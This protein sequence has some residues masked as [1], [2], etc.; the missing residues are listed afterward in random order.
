MSLTNYL[1]AFYYLQAMN[2]RAFWDRGKLRRYQNKKLR[3][4]VMYAYA[5]SPFYRRKFKQTEIRP[6]EIRTIEDLNKLPIIRK[7]ELIKNLDDVVSRTFNVT[8]LKVQRTSGSTGRPLYIYMTES[9]NEFRKA[10][11][12]RA[13]I[14][15]GQKPWHKWIT[16]TSPLHFAETTR[17]QRLLGLYAV[18]PISV[19]DDIATQISKIEKLKPEVLDGYS[20]SILLL[21]KEVHKRGLETIKPKFLVSGAELIDN[22]S[23][24]FIEDVFAAPLY[25]QYASVE[26]ERMAWQCPEKT[27]YH[28]DSDSLVMQFIDENGDEVEP[29]EEG[30]IVCTSLFNYAMPFIRYALDDV[31]I[32]S[33]TAE[34]PCGRTFPLMKVME[35]R[36]TSLLVFPSGR[37][38]APF[39]FMLAVW[40]FKYYGCIDLFRI[41]QKRKDLILFKLRLNE[42][43]VDESAIQKELQRHL[44][45][46]LNIKEDETTFEV[47]FVD[48]MPPDKT[49]KFQIV[50][51]E[52]N[53]EQI[54]DI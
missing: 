18:T 39:A 51:S 36:K 49:G 48:E 52:V 23:R 9:E 22:S 14:V 54:R 20:N 40:N 47:E 25:D 29:G 19:F 53:Q 35:G 12:L 5:N 4:I 16:I 1:R 15:C 46:T 21:A 38:L 37:V 6:E 33:E 30:E 41:I 34:C 7:D 31:G 2:R 17:L 44:K 27:E 8:N 11:H 10:K 3:K 28:I 43:I 24:E 42:S 50:D 26:F 32:P 13:Q 45:E